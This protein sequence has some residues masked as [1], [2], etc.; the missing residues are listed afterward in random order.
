MLT[1]RRSPITVMVVV[2]IVGVKP[3]GHNSVVLPVKILTSDSLPKA[4]SLFFVIRIILIVGCRF[5]DSCISS[6]IS[7]VFP[8][9][10]IKSK[11]WR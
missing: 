8:L 7:R 9:F 1:T 4:L 3:N 6:S 2:D 5:R 10:E 11:T